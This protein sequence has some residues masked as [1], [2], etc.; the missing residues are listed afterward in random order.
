[1][2]DDVKQL[3]STQKAPPAIGPYS[4][5]V[6]FGRFLFISGQIP[7]N[8]DTKEIVKG[9]IEAQTEQVLS[10]IL[11]ILQS[12]GM[13]LRDVVKTTL[14]IRRLE[15]FDRVNRIYKTYFSDNPPARSTVGVAGLPKDADIEIEAIACR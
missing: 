4:Q 9:S 2:S 13:D 5:A 3:F 7:V 1:M 15:D 6:K 11:A 10:N 12:A 14:F 8:P